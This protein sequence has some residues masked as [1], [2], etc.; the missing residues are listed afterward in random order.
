MTWQPEDEVNGEHTIQ[1]QVHVRVQLEVRVDIFFVN[2]ALS[3]LSKLPYTPLRCSQLPLPFCPCPL[4]RHQE[5][6]EEACSWSSLQTTLQCTEMLT[7]SSLLARMLDVL[8]NKLLPLFLEG[9]SKSYQRWAIARVRADS[10][11]LSLA[12]P[13]MENQSVV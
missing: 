13:E 1:S 3:L 6:S 4:L 5:T 9:L 2:L 12:E 8:L 10:S 11:V 7:F